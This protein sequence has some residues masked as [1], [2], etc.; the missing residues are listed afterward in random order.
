MICGVAAGVALVFTAYRPG[1]E[2][3][4]FFA[5]AVLIQLR[6]LCNM[7]DGMVA[8]QTGQASP[9]GEL[10]NEVPDR[11]SDTAVFIGAGYAWGSRPELGYLAACV[12]LFVAYVR[13]E[14][15]VAG[16]HQE[17]CGPLAKPQRMFL[18]TVAALYLALVPQSWQPV[19]APLKITAS[20]PPEAFNLWPAWR[21]DV[22]PTLTSY[23]VVAAA[24]AVIVVGGLI[25]AIRRLVRIA[26]ALRKA[27]S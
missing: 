6:L 13:A 18:M 27:R 14:G 23:G 17:F 21:S 16:A 10:Y 4:C 20:P 11:V 26:R 15:K 12:A 22:S 3:P 19:L 25:T 5:A 24:L 9:V 7:L 2:R 8:V 1:W